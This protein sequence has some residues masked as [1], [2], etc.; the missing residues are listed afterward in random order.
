MSNKKLTERLNNE[1]DSLGVPEMILQRVQACSKMFKLPK[2]KVE[3]L[4]YGMN[5][6]DSDTI[7]KIASELDVNKDWLLGCSN[8]KTK[9]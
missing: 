9:H 6:F 1:L 7:E 4:L 2:Y 3:A 8:E 5:S